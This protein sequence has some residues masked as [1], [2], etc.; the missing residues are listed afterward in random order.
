MLFSLL[1]G[2]RLLTGL[3]EQIRSTFQCLHKYADTDRPEEWEP[4]T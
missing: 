2:V 3:N 4:I 1:N